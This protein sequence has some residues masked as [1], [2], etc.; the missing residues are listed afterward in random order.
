MENPKQHL[1]KDFRII[2]FS[3]VFSILLL[4]GGFIRLL[5]QGIHELKYLGSF[6]AGVFFTSIFTTAPATAFFI[7]AVKFNSLLPVAFFGGL[8]AVF[9]D[10][11]IFRFA[12]DR[13]KDDIL[14]LLK[15]SKKERFV[16]I[17]KLKFFRWLLPFFGALIIAS[18]LPD[19]LGLLMMGISNT[20]NSLFIL[21]SFSF[22]FLGI[23]AIGLITQMLI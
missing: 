14:Y 20:K 4:D 15:Q 21:L 9:G 8:G 7:E 19:E 22:N 1:Q 2:I 16:S 23:L 10:L 13:L 6:I 18:P 3:I 5:F 11:V 12:K 17:F